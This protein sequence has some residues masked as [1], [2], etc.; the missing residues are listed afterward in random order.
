MDREIV[1]ITAYTPQKK[2]VFSVEAG[3]LAGRRAHFSI[4]TDPAVL[5][6]G[7]RFVAALHFP[8]SG[9]DGRAYVLVPVDSDE[10]AAKVFAAIG[11][12][13]GP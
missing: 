2:A 10:D 8:P 9:G 1:R 12:S 11:K 6:I 3:K 13:A 5:A 4:A 7:Q